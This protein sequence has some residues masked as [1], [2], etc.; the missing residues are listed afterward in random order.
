MSNALVKWLTPGMGLKRW[1]LVAALGF[2]IQ[3][4][5]I[6]LLTI[7]VYRLWRYDLDLAP[8][9]VT[10]GGG[11]LVVGLGLGLWGGRRVVRAVAT[12]VRA[13]P[14]APT[15]VESLYRNRPR[16]GPKLVAIG[17][18]TG[19]ASLLRGLKV[20]SDHITAVVAM[21]DDGGS[22]GRLR[23]ELG[24]LPPGDVR[25]CL[26]ALAGEEKLMADL[27]AY[28]FET[29]GLGGH[30]FGN[31]FL[32]ALSELTGDLEQA[33]QAASR[34]LAVR[35]QV[36]PAT[37]AELTLAARLED[38][39]EVR[40]ESAISASASPVNR[41]WCEPHDPAALPEAIRAIREAEAIILGPG[42]LYTS[43]VPNLLIPEILSEIKHSK[44]PRIYIC[45]V[46]T[47]PGETD[48]YSVADHV[49]ALQAI[50]G[51]EL[52]DW[53]LVNEELPHVLLEAYRA[54]GQN[55]VR[56]DRGALDALGVK[57]LVGKLIDEH[58]V[59]RHRPE[60]LGK[61]VIDWVTAVRREPTGK[62]LAF[63]P[64]PDRARR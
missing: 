4:A 64:D 18:G 49:A 16:R 47:Q 28:R 6:V 51:R 12:A 15:I 61:A 1:L 48:G 26:L 62:L 54:K 14:A 59:V 25:N 42:S 53:V 57:P 60:A 34:V 39:T 50:G 43:I 56:L 36:L 7:A 21:T 11:G 20:H 52:F 35:G 23:S 33:I 32:T 44:A 5:G 29:G 30:S 24:V 31:L 8:W 40:G 9:L 46:M 45:N 22:S 10:W 41:I 58:T 38:G 27:F 3:G 55:P 13:T 2:L 63:P 37:L 19:L 17:G